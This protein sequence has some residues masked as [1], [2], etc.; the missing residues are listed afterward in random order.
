MFRSLPPA[1]NPIETRDILK[2]LRNMFD[3]DCPEHFSR[4]LKT[5]FKVKHCF[6]TSS[7]T[8]ALYLALMSLSRRADKKEVIIP[9]YTCPSILAAVIRAGLKPV[10]CDFDHETS[11]MDISKLAATI[12][13]DTLA[14]ISVHLFGIR[15]NTDGIREL[16]A[17]RHIFHIED[18]AQAFDGAIMDYEAGS[19]FSSDAEP[20]GT[21][22]ILSFGR[23]KPLTLLQGGAVI[24]DSDTLANTLQETA[25]VL[26][27]QRS[28]D[29]MTLILKTALYA[30]FFHPHL[31][32]MA[33]GMPFL[34]LGHTIFNLA[35]EAKRVNAFTC[36]L[37]SIM[38]NRMPQMIASRRRQAFLFSRRLSHLHH[39]FLPFK[40]GRDVLLRF[41]LLMDNKSQRDRVLSRL[42][43]CRLGC[44]SM[45]EAPL[46][47]F[48]DTQKYFAGNHS[49]SNAASF[50]ER[51][52][53]LPLHGFVT[54][55][56]IN[57]I[58][59]IIEAGIQNI[60]R[61]TTVW[62]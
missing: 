30:A 41:P 2:A 20:D 9:A 51:I 60:N 31:Y 55:N 53:T 4:K 13:D 7:G 57:A 56:D 47:L 10:L 42:N 22:E 21:V 15:E 24:T 19:R 23:G 58:G 36:A 52:L 18:A 38:L 3:P 29:T 40:Q 37:G 28:H 25:N 54:E 27:V 26:E 1:G 61:T 59:T 44:T 45:Y 33:Q 35:F 16:I 11:T 34:K 32:W 17:G 14:V 43:H 50:A 48:K 5:V 46:H 12:T 49:Y 6:L 8:A 62:E 39:R